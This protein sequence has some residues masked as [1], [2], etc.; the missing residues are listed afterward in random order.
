MLVVGLGSAGMRY[1]Q[2]M[3]SALDVLVGDRVFPL[4]FFLCF[5]TS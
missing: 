5:T 1:L 2:G 4:G 3:V